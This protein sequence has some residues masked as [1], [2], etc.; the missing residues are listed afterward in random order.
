MIEPHSIHILSMSSKEEGMTIDLIINEL[1]ATHHSIAISNVD[2]SFPLSIS[3]A[4]VDLSLED[5]ISV[6]VGM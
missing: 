5:C 2:Q 3:I 4:A 1:I 6:I